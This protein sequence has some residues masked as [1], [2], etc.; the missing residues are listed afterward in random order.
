MDTKDTED[1]RSFTRD[2]SDRE[3]GRRSRSWMP[4]RRAEDSVPATGAGDEEPDRDTRPLRTVDDR[5]DRRAS[6]RVVDDREDRRASDRR[7]DGR[8]MVDHRSVTRAQ[9][10]RHG[11]VKVGSAFFGWLTATGMAVLLTALLA[12]AGAAVGVAHNTDLTKA[13]NTATSDSKTVG[14]VGAIVLLLIVLVAYY[15]GGYVAARM[16]RFNGVRQGVAVW[17]WT[18]VIAVVLAVLAAAAG[19]KYNVSATLNI[20]PRIPVREGT[21][22][23]AG[24]IALLA[25]AIAALVGAILGGLAGMRYHRRVDHTVPVAGATDRPL[26]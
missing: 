15:C 10:E 1:G 25:V 24:I 16:A 21:L 11:G 17:V 23:T 18:L 5:E 26:D 4:R 8:A 9:K 13:A 14:I 2:E 6:D 7:G 22:T 3:D 19:Q 12:A 20:F